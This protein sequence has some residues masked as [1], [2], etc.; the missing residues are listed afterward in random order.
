MNA[1]D[2]PRFGERI[3]QLRLAKNWSQEDLAVRS[4]L[5]PTYIG[6]I[7]RGERNLGLDNILKLARALDEH[8]S[9]LFTGFQK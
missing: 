9:A 8:P 7:E 6:G 4:G 1:T 5:H 3:R 2:R